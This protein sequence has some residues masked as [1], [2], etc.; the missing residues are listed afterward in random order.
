[1]MLVFQASYSQISCDSYSHPTDRPI[2]NQDTY[3]T[4]NEQTED[5][6]SHMVSF[7]ASLAQFICVFILVFCFV[8]FFFCWWNKLKL[9]LFKGPLYS[10][11]DSWARIK[12]WKARWF[13]D[14]KGNEVGSGL[15]TALRFTRALSNSPEKTKRKTSVDRLF[16]SRHQASF[17][18]GLIASP[19]SWSWFKVLTSISWCPLCCRDM[20][21]KDLSTATESTATLSTVREMMYFTQTK[22]SY[23]RFAPPPTPESP[24]QDRFKVLPTPGPKRLDLFPWLPGD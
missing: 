15:V 16:T 18:M 13:I 6:Q 12:N 5:G 2:Q 7:W 1:M 4:L 21:H 24:R 22:R 23:F 17:K 19:C 3:S 11:G 20:F 14:H 8:L 9:K 10:L